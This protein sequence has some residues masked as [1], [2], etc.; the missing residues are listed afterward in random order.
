MPFNVF[1]N[2]SSSYDNGK[3][4]DASMFV[5]NFYFG[6]NYIESNIEDYID[7]EKQFRFKKLP[8]PVENSIAVCKSQV[9]RKLNDPS[10]IRNTT[11]VDFNDKCLDNVRFTKVN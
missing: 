2:S 8:C 5:G 7:L 10:I 6:T 4:F 3:K 1:G 11:H 9:D